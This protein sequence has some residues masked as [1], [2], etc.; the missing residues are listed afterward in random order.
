[1]TEIERNY[2]KPVCFLLEH[3]PCV[4]LLGARQAGKTTLLRQVL[5]NAPFF[6]L[7]RR[8]DF[9]R[10]QADPDFFLVEHDEPIILDEAQFFPALF[11]ALRVRIDER[12][13]LNGRFLVS[14]S[15]SPSLLQ[16]ISETLAGRAAILEIGTLHLEEA[17][18]GERSA[19]YDILADGRFDD[20]GKLQ[21]VWTTEQVFESCLFGGYPEPFLKRRQKLVYSLWMENYFK[22]YLERDIRRLFPGLNSEAYR[23]FIQ[24]L[25]FNSGKIVNYSNFARSLGVSQPTARSYFQIAEGTFLWRHLPSFDH[26][27]HKRATKMPKGFLRDT[28]LIHHLLNVGTVDQMRGHPDFGSI[29]EA[30]ISEQ[31][32]KG[33]QVGLKPFRHYHYRARSQNEVDLVIENEHG[34]I[35]IEIKV[36]LSASGRQLRTLKEFVGAFDCPAGFL[37]NNSQEVIKLADRIWQIPAACL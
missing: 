24:M 36:G 9:E 1:M 25:G 8:S 26:N 30:F 15:S 20:C 22:T 27:P 23:R 13:N 31:I 16:E 34:A 19:F 3:F 7:E 6:D 28:G 33:L 2:K 37:V 21:P 11:N 12:R 5:P 10:I 4:V 29:W 18:Q 35:P 14:G 32:I 17:W